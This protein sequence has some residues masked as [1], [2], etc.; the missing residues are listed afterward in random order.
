MARLERIRMVG[1]QHFADGRLSLPGYNMA[2][3]EGGKEL[4]FANMPPIEIVRSLMTEGVDCEE[5][6]RLTEIKL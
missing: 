2:V 6:V 3:L 1:E 4:F 5:F